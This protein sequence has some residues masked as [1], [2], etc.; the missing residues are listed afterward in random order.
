M[1]PT[2]I[3]HTLPGFEAIAAD[4]ITELEGATV[5]GT[6][7]VGDKSGMV[8]FTYSGDPADLLE[9]RTVEDV[10]VQVAVAH[11]FAPTYA[12]LRGLREYVQKA[13]LEPAVA[14]ARQLKPGRGG[15][16]KLRFRVVA[17][18]A[19]QAHFRR[20]DA[21]E[22][23]EKGIT[24]RAD[25]RWVLAEEGALEFW[26]TI[27]PG[28]ALLTLR[29]S[30]EGMRHRPYQVE[31]L[32]AS[33]RP[34]G[35]AALVRLTRP[36]PEDVFL[37][38]MCGAGTILIERAHAGRYRQLLGGDVDPEA[39]AAAKANIGPRYKPIEVRE[40]DARHLPLDAGSV[41]AAAVNLPFGRQIGSPEENRRLYPAFL[42]EMERVLRPGARLVLLS[43]DWRTL[44]DAL[45][46]AGRLAQRESHRVW[47]LGAPARI[48][49]AQKG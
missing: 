30:D 44:E 17:R 40:W 41:T 10:F 20:V 11:E 48:V 8:L 32:P 15:H 3:A 27:L 19:G 1:V 43:G 21:Q 47:V 2:Y 26:L 33:L 49:V 35:A 25:R 9:L 42:R 31:H 38:P 14:L 45:R 4:E 34:A 29:L 7:T 28:E 6:R 37:D 16:G 46:R 39:V 13:Q 24:A 12:A 22:A 23:V 36:T 5:R 18:M